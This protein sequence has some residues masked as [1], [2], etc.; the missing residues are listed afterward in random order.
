MLVMATLYGKFG[1]AEDR[2]RFYAT[3]C[4]GG[5]ASGEAAI[6]RMMDER[7]FHTALL[8][9]KT[10]C[11]YADVSVFFSGARPGR[12]ARKTGR[13]RPARRFLAS[14][15]SAFPGS[16]CFMMSRNLS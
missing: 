1:G 4:N 5:Y 10:T 15:T 13:Y 12:R 6:R 14:V 3:A 11:N 16:A 2:L 8:F 7:R 9:P